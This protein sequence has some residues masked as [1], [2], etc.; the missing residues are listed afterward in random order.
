MASKDDKFWVEDPCI[1]FSDMAIFPVKNMTKSEKLNALTRL[2]III[3]ITM[4]FMEYENWFVFL[5]LAVLIIIIINYYGHSESFKKQKISDL[6]SN[7]GSNSTDDEENLIENFSIVPTYSGTD[8]QQTVIAPLF[9]EE[10]QNP[11]PAYDL[12]TNVPYPASSGSRDTFEMPL[13]PQSYPYGQYLTRTNLL[14]SDEYYSHLGCGGARSAREFQNSNF[15]RH[16][17][18]RR[19][20]MSRIF[21]KSLDRRFR[22]SCSDSFSPFTSY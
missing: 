9:A 22:H 10:W 12:Y 13:K 1:L 2:A 18:A 5:S 15:L 7:D 6:S 19:E 14:P 3:A 17:L 8:F 21:K 4:Y 11:P 20:N 16:D